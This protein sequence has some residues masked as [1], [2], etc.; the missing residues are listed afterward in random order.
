[1]VV[2]HF[3]AHRRGEGRLQ[4]SQA[5]HGDPEPP[6]SLHS[7]LILRVVGINLG[8]HGCELPKGLVHWFQQVH[9]PPYLGDS[10]QQTGAL[11]LA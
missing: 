6:M 9:L 1:M 10:G 3:D 8:S 4:A 11:L 5:E 2:K 7:R